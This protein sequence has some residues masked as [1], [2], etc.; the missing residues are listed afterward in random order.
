MAR[1]S[2][3]ITQGGGGPAR[4]L[5]RPSASS[6]VSTWPWRSLLFRQHLLSL[7]SALL[8]LPFGFETCCLSSFWRWTLPRVSSLLLCPVR[9]NHT[10]HPCQFSY[11]SGPAFPPESFL[12]KWLFS[13]EIPH[14]VIHP[15]ASNH[16]RSFFKVCVSACDIWVTCGSVSTICFLSLAMWS[17]LGVWYMWTPCRANRQRL[18]LRWEGPYSRGKLFPPGRQ[19]EQGPCDGQDD[20]DCTLVP[21]DD[22]YFG[23]VLTEKAQP[24]PARSWDAYQGASS[25]PAVISL[26][27]LPCC[28]GRWPGASRRLFLA[29][30]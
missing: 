14:L 18:W 22:G 11:L 28:P 1:G 27:Y 21:G 19:G 2:S 12:S 9:L 7:L 20:L 6:R 17:G 25:S 8:T 10:L 16:H 23:F 24:F 26:S 3:K 5:T 30:F 4:A 15:P 13:G 29:W